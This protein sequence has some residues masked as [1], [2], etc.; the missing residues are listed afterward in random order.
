MVR[1]KGHQLVV[2]FCTTLPTKCVVAVQAR[3][4][5]VFIRFD[6]SGRAC[7]FNQTAANVVVDIQ[8]YMATSAFDDVAVTLEEEPGE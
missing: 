2:V 1:H 4:G 5:L 3:A 7:V 6:A 8:G